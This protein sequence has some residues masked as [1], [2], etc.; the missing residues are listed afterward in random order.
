MIITISGDLGSGKSTVAKLVSEELKFKYYSTGALMRRLAVD[1]KLPLIELNELAKKDKRIDKKI[2]DYQKKLGEKEDDFILE[3]RLGFY[4]IPHSIKVYLKVEPM[5]GAHRV[6][7]HKR[8]DE[9]FRTIEQAMRIL[10]KRRELENQRYEQYYGI[11]P[12]KLDQYD[13]VI[14][15]TKIP[16]TKVAEKIIKYVKEK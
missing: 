13:L 2:D 4:F 5:E 14:D 7:K 16:A 12:G 15:T 3:G 9:R 1:M 6:L 11:N 10:K 8:I